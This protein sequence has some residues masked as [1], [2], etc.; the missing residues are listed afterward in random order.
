MVARVNFS[1]LNND[2]TSDHFSGTDFVG[3]AVPKITYEAVP[4][5]EPRGEESDE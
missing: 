4:A 2:A 3:E 5:V 1:R